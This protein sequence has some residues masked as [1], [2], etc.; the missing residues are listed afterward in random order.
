MFSGRRELGFLRREALTTG[1]PD[2]EKDRVLFKK[3][4]IQTA[5]CESRKRLESDPD[6]VL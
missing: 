2:V 6:S 1:N 5:A 3:L 4:G